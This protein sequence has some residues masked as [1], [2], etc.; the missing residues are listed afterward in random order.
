MKEDYPAQRHHPGVKKSGLV[1]GRLHTLVLGHQWVHVEAR[2]V[3]ES[4]CCASFYAA[5]AVMGAAIL[6]LTILSSSG[7]RSELA[8]TRW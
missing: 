8:A 6:F 5:I 3:R 4:A 1:I 2:A 7:E